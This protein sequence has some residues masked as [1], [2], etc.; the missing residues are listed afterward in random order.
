MFILIDLTDVYILESI[1]SRIYTHF[2]SMLCVW[3]HAM[4]LQ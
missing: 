4:Y 3:N 1:T 2:G